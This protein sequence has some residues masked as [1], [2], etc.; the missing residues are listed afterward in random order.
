[1][2]DMKDSKQQKSLWNLVHETVLSSLGVTY[3]GDVG[4]Q[5]LQ[6]NLA[7]EPITF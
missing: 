6:K 5:N 3:K 7:T 4:F 2:L 1:M